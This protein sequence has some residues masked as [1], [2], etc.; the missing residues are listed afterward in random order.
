[1][2]GRL[3]WPAA[4]MPGHYLMPIA[5]WRSHARS[6]LNASTRGGTMGS[7]LIE[8]KVNAEDGRTVLVSWPRKN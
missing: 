7:R 3:S 8:F 2:R 6:W 1:M 4:A 5:K